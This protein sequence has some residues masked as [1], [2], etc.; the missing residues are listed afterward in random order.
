MR[1]GLFFICLMFSYTVLIAQTDH[2]LQG[3]YKRYW[4]EA[5]GVHIAQ[6]LTLTGIASGRY[7]LAEEGGESPD[8]TSGYWIKKKIWRRHTESIDVV[9]LNYENDYHTHYLEIDRTGCLTHIFDN[10]DQI[11]RAN[12]FAPIKKWHD[13]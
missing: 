5:K 3:A 6:T 9:I 10:G 12:S 8:F 11:R 13:Q 7:T 1:T 2:G 4:H